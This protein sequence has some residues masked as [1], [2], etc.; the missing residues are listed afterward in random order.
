[1]QYHIHDGPFF[2]STTKD[3]GF[4]SNA[5]GTH[6]SKRKWYFVSILNFVIKTRI[7]SISTSQKVRDGHSLCFYRPLEKAERRRKKNRKKKEKKKE[8][9][10]REFINYLIFFSEPVLS[11]NE[12]DEIQYNI[13]TPGSFAFAERPNGSVSIKQRKQ[14]FCRLKHIKENLSL[15]PTFVR[16][17]CYTS[18]NISFKVQAAFEFCLVSGYLCY[19]QLVSKHCQCCQH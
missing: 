8:K 5:K 15:L 9:K 6:H 4:R 7:S 16:F 2:N 13:S 12:L 3:G 17:H 11:S 18:I 14:L 19:W 1:M 10:K